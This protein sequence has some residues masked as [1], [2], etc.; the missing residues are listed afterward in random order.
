MNLGS[1]LHRLHPDWN[2]LV[3]FLLWPCLT[4]FTFHA[5]SFSV[6]Y[7]CAQFRLWPNSFTPRCSIFQRAIIVPFLDDVFTKQMFLFFIWRK[8]SHL[9]TVTFPGIFSK[10]YCYAN[11]FKESVNSEQYL[12]IHLTNRCISWCDNVLVVE[13]PQCGKH[14]IWRILTTFNQRLCQ[15]DASQVSLLSSNQVCAF[16]DEMHLSLFH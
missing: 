13:F 12:S 8:I 9:T 1:H 11:F 7:G 4:F 15:V 6:L 16:F 3:S 14:N 2:A 5:L 10:T